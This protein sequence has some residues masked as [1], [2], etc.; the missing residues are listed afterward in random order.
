M[1]TSGTRLLWTVLGLVF[2]GI[3]VAGFVV[4]LGHLTGIDE[5]APLLWSGL[6][7]F[8]RGIHPWGLVVLGGLGALLGWLGHRLLDRQLRAGDDPAAGYLDPRPVVDRTPD[9]LPGVTRVHGGGLVRGLE[10]DLLR[11]PSIRRAVAR[12]AGPLPRPELWIELRLNPGVGP[13]EVRDHVAAAID[14]FRVTSGLAPSR[15]EI[16]IRVD[17]A[18]PH[19]VT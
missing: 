19:R 17:R 4:S 6:R 16:T 10:R 11:D 15:L 7:G 12:L 14:R 18:G 9:G 13:P 3:G 5:D 8:W 2:T 1:S